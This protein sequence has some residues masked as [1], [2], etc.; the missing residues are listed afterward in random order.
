MEVLLDVRIPVLERFFEDALIGVHASVYH[1]EDLARARL[2]HRLRLAAAAA[3]PA[4][5]QL[6]CEVTGRDRRLVDHDQ[7]VLG[8]ALPQILETELHETA[9][10]SA[11]HKHRVPHVL[12]LLA[13]VAH[14]LD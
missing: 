14:E 2:R 4:R 3:A 13:V 1:R 6:H 12:P 7:Q 5:L 11:Q 9:Q 8:V 10:E